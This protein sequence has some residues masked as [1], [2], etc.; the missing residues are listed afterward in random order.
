MEI[1]CAAAAVVVARPALA[2]GALMM[3]VGIESKSSSSHPNEEAE[4]AGVVA[5]MFVVVLKFV[6]VVVFEGSDEFEEWRLVDE[7]DSWALPV[8]D[9]SHWLAVLA[10][11]CAK[12]VRY[13]SAAFVLYLASPVLDS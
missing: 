8:V 11:A 10:T 4:A 6:V 13:C 5:L 7:L 9:S 2:T 3:G 1:F 12:E